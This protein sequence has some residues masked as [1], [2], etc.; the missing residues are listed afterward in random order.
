MIEAALI[1]PALLAFIFGIV[2]VS[3]V[4][5]VQHSLQEATDAAARCAAI[6]S[7]TCA[8]SNAIAAFAASRAAGIDVDAANFAHTTASCGERVTVS[9]HYMSVATGFVPIDINLGA[10]ACHP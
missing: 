4:M 5:W 3:R 7:I 1:L 6:D 2:E 9:Y 8:N 10:S